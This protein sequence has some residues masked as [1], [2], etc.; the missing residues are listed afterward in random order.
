[1]RPVKRFFVTGTDTGV[2]KTLVSGA[3]LA[4]LES[5]GLEPRAFKPYE[6]GGVGDAE[7]LRRRAGARQDLD[8]V[9]VA[10]FR[11]PLAPGVAA[12]L[13]RRPV[14]FAK[15]RR[16]LERAMGACAV[17]E[18]AGGLLV[19]LDGRHDV[20]DLAQAL[21]LP[22]VLVGRAGLG[23]LNHVGLSLAELARRKLPVAAVVLV[24]S[25]RGVDASVE[26]NVRWL[27]RRHPGVRVLGPV[28]FHAHPARRLAAAR[29][30]VA[31]LAKG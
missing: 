9:C 2:G 30:V 12:E 11:A 17:V 28:G 20:A 5:N 18:G 19:P 22:V 26:H 15:V 1:M 10:R 13:E 21:Q 14:S 7:F 24:Q 3:L 27:E 6:S 31:G 16:H 8:E 25:V 23:T 4:E 29:R